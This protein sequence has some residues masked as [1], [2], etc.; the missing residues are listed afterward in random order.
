MS[1]LNEL[2]ANAENAASLMLYKTGSISAMV[3]LHANI[4][5]V[6]LP[7]KC[8]GPEHVE[9]EQQVITF[10]V[11]ACHRAGA[12]EGLVMISE[13]WVAKLIKGDTRR[14]SERE[15]KEEKVVICI[16]DKDLKKELAIYP[17]IRNGK[18]VL[19]GARE[20]AASTGTFK[21][22]LDGAFAD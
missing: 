5:I 3:L 6:A 8:A 22:W 21:S 16:W 15:D 17:I 13:S 18:K 12:F 1:E 11:K 2:L 4:G 9:L 20:K 7:Y 14:P 10:T 19:M